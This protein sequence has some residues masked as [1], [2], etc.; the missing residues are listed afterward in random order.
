MGVAKALS[1]QG[2]K[3]RSNA[4]FGSDRGGNL[5]NGTVLGGQDAQGAVFIERFSDLFPVEGRPSFCVD[6]SACLASPECYEPL[7]GRPLRGFS[8]EQEAVAHALANP[9]ASGAGSV[10][11]LLRCSATSASQPYSKGTRLLSPDVITSGV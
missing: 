2:P 8:T 11:T 1:C 3:P 5:A 4:R 7:L 9:K 10:A 6:R